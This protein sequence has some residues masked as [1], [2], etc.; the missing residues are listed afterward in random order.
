MKILLV[1][2]ASTM[3]VVLP[4][5]GL[6]YLAAYLSRQLPG[7]D[8][9]ILDC[10]RERLATEHFQKFLLEVK[11]DVIGFTALSMELDSAFALA[12]I[13]KA[14][15]KESCII[16]GGPHASSVPEK[17]LSNPFIDYVFRGEAEIGLTEFLKNFDS[18]HKFNAP[19][20]GYR[21]DGQMCFNAPKVVDTLDAIPFPDYAKI[22]FEKYPK[23]Y[24]M[25]YSPAAPLVS[26]RG[27]PFRCT[28]CAG[29]EVSGRKWRYRSAGNIMEEI[30][31]LQEAYRIREVDFWDDNF[32][33]DKARVEALCGALCKLKR[34]IRWW[35]P[36][37]IHLNTVDKGLLLRMK[38]SGCYAVAFGIESGS[39]RVRRDMR[40]DISLDKLREMVEFSSKIG[41]RTQGFFILGYPTERREDI[42]ETIRL[43][44]S[45][46]LLRASFCLSAPCRLRDLS[47]TG[48]EEQ[49]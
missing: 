34:R 25:K 43:A 13:A 39:E 14:T 28:F 30:A 15:L 3:H 22:Q 8:I 24:F 7:F 31:Y 37:G 11:P 5:I 23:M 42:E 17:M 36:N 49:T 44:K 18:P 46:P 32:S 41:L 9:R 4:P 16:F 20:L 26:S 29:H 1:K 19:G 6:G 47:R 38:E 12:S 45:L 10:N 27:C 2:P 48:R 40:K 35:C 21:K 33:L